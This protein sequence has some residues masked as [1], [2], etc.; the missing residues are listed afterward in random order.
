[1]AFSSWRRRVAAFVAIASI[2]PVALAPTNALAQV[3]DAKT[4]LADANK[5]ASAKDWLT[6]ARLF[7]AAN[8]AQPSDTAL[9]GLANA[10]YQS[11]QFGDAFT[12]YTEWNTLYGAKAAAA[13]KQTVAA[14]LKELEA[15]TAPVTITVNEPG[16]TIAID[17]KVVGT[18]PLTGPVRVGAGPRRLRVTKD[19]FTPFEQGPNI[20]AGTPVTLDVK[21]VSTAVKGKV[22]VKEKT[23]KPVRVIV[24]GVDMG[25]APWTGELDPGQHD[26][27]ARAAGL[28][29]MPQKVTV[30]RG[31]TQEVE[32]VASS[33]TAPVKIATSDSKGLIYLDGK[34]VGE[35]SFVGDIPSGEHKLKVTR[36]GYDP[37]EE[38]ITV[39]DKEPFSRTITLKIASKIETGP[40]VTVE[41]L[42]G[43][44]GGFSLLGMATPGGTGNDIEK[45]LCDNRTGTPELV[46]CEAP[47][48]V[49]GGLGGF[50]GYHWDPVGIE[51]FLA[52][53]FDT[54]TM[55]TDWDA[56]NTDPG[57][58]PD[59]ARREEYK[60]RRLG[61]MA[62]A[63][64]RL[65]LQSS[66]I[67]FTMAAGAGFTRR[68]LFLTRETYA[69]DNS[70]DDDTYVSEGTG[71]WSPIVSFEPSVMYRLTPTVAAG[72][73]IQMYLDAA[74]TIFAGNDGQ[75]PRSNKE[76]FHRLGQRP[77]AT[78][79][80][81]LASNI[82]I[83]IGPYLGMMFGP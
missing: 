11:G 12:T 8:K 45:R 23:G 46:G 6:A 49:G 29:A 35:G 55:K 7:D 67:R 24:D 64:V 17:D 31:Q 48:G 47:D 54:R 33:S 83:Y 39:K 70:G 65:T 71:Y 34:L 52:G 4:S 27:G 20:T 62:L 42:E 40:M 19:G 81:D 38:D 14:R 72:L 1:M 58:G 44:Y 36:E 75:N 78:N 76:T 41:R 77:L 69:K 59:P 73:G 18:S 32:L 51:L 37:F 28:A 60:L 2:S 13:K 26:I 61:A 25:D 43:L 16:A 74:N 68:A 66:K 56:A 21:L 30:E 57:I 50:I 82:Q 9:E 5:A 15:K 79:E 22:V 10:Y 53:Q 3:V 80:L 63:R